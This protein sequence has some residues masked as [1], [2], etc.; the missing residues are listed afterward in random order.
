MTGKRVKFPAVIAR[1]EPFLYFNAAAVKYI[2]SP[3]IEAKETPDMVLFIPSNISVNPKVV[4]KRSAGRE[5]TVRALYEKRTIR[6][7]DVFKL[8][9]MP[10][11]T[12]AIKKHEPIMRKETAHDA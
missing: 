3:H 9:R 1:G 11:G 2:T 5:I 7:G 12:L 10:N 4:I 6:E 8:H